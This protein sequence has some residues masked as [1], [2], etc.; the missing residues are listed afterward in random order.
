[1]YVIAQARWQD[2]SLN[3]TAFDLYS[4]LITVVNNVT[5]RPVEPYGLDVIVALPN[6]TFGDIWPIMAVYSPN[7]DSI[8]LTD[9]QHLLLP[10]GLVMGA[11]NPQNLGQGTSTMRWLVRGESDSGNVPVMGYE[12][13]FYIENVYLPKGTVLR[14]DVTVT[15]T[16]DYHG[17]IQ[18]YPVAS[19]T[20]AAGFVMQSGQVST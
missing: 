1:M 15:L 12:A 14:E 4:L 9:G 8:T 13:Q 10:A 7:Q 20:L 5:D 17:S 2:Q 11:Y 18:T 19:R 16:W 3:S 6:G